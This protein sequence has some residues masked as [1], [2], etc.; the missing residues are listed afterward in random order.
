MKR[1]NYL[2]GIF[3]IALVTTSCE[4]VSYVTS[5]YFC[6]CNKTEKNIIIKTYGDGVLEPNK[7]IPIQGGAINSKEDYVHPLDT[8]SL[9][10]YYEIEYDGKTYVVDK[11]VKNGWYYESNFYRYYGPE[12]EEY[13]DM[14]REQW[15]S[16]GWHPIK[17]YVI[18]Y[19]FDITE[20][21]INSLPE[22]QQ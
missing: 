5:Q 19:S 8:I 18:L 7:I 3:V 17:V 15:I 4:N 14:E 1:I 9:P 10:Y 6:I 22:K 13:T 2:I 21:F 11:E 20:D 16:D 12:V